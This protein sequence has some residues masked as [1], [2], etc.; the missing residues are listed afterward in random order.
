MYFVYNRK[1]RTNNAFESL[2]A[3]FKR[4]VSRQ[5][6]HIVLLVHVFDKAGRC[7]QYSCKSKNRFNFLVPGF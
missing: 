1:H 2:H 4:E 3:R 5:A 7:K 6:P